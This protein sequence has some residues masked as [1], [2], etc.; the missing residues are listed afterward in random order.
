[1]NSRLTKHLKTKEQREEFEKRILGCQDVLEVISNL[2]EGDLRKID[3]DSL[4]KE[5]Y[6]MPSWAEYQAD[7]N[8]S[9]RQL[10][11]ILTLLEV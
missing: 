7:R 1:M 6:F 9:K 10:K 3:K 11:K 8:G 2:L 4:N 5:H